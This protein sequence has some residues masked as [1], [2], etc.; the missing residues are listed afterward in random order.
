MHTASKLTTIRTFIKVA[1]AVMAFSAMSL[2]YGNNFAPASA[3]SHDL[4]N[5]QS[6]CK[7]DR[8]IM[9]HSPY[10]GQQLALR[11]NAP[12]V[13]A[14]LR[15]IKIQRLHQQQIQLMQEILATIKAAPEITGVNVATKPQDD[16]SLDKERDQLIGQLSDLIQKRIEGDQAI[17]T[18]VNTINQI[19]DTAKPKSQNAFKTLADHQMQIT[20]DSNNA[21]ERHPELLT[22]SEQTQLSTIRNH[23]GDWYLAQKQGRKNEKERYR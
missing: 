20:I 17:S 14:V 10:F 11:T 3:M 23:S 16:S 7:T 21:I 15:D 18:L 8:S 1:L 6:A 9:Q 5:D 13:Y 2:S 19:D 4:I 12:E 22:T